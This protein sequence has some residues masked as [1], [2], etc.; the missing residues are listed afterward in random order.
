MTTE[1]RDPVAIP[2]PGDFPRRFVPHDI[3]LGEWPEIEPLFESLERREIHSPR[4]IEQWLLQWSEL[5]ACIAE[6]GARRHIAMTCHTDDA[7]LERRHLHFIT[8]IVPRLKPRSDALER[9][10]LASPHRARLDRRRHEVHDRLVENDVALFREEN[11][12]LQTDDQRLQSEHHK[13][14]GAQ[15]VEFRGER[16]TMPQMQRLLEETDRALR[17]E[18]WLAVT[19]RRLQDEEALSALF[20]RMLDLRHR[21]ARNAGFDNFRDYQHRR[22]ARFD[23]TPQDCE[24]F[25]DAAEKT[26][27]PAMRELHRERRRLLNLDALRPWDT[28]VDPLGRPPMRPFETGAQLVGGC[29]A[30]FDGVAPVLAQ[31]FDTL[32]DR[33]LLD[34]ESRPGKAPGGYQSTLDEVRLPFIF[35][36][37]AGM[38]GDVFTLLHEG[39]HALHALAARHEPL[40]AYREAPIEFCEVASMGMEMMALDALDRF[41]TGEMARRSRRRHFEQ[42]LLLLPWVAQIDAF[43]HWLCTHPGHSRE[44]RRA[45]WLALD[46]RF[47][48]EIDWTGHEHWRGVSWQRQLHLFQVPLYYIEYGIAQLGA[49]QLWRS[50]RANAERAVEQYR[51]ALAL[52]GSRPLPELFETA[53]LRFDFSAATMAPL[54]EA[55]R[56]ELSRLPV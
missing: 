39:G 16:R 47:G 18:A 31:D 14:T 19:A 3:D 38:D 53:G 9:R 15:L 52:G 32:S 54:V 35:M 50:H 43:Q 51:R 27:V 7:E 11:V 6:E 26:C 55:V 10:Y 24:A 4:E 21:I 42:V 1:L 41:Y 23:Y 29:R 46:E 2:R 25:H 40:H 33:G 20:D 37:A 5:S 17:E 13:I 28:A 44:E 34:L 30:V 8:E 45:A 12:P 22:L 48:G 56:D 36:N 49:L